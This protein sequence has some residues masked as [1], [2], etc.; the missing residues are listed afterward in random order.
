MADAEEEKMSPT[1]P[2]IHS[3]L[4]GKCVEGAKDSDGRKPQGFRHEEKKKQ[5]VF[6]KDAKSVDGSKVPRTKKAG[7][8]GAEEQKNMMYV[9]KKVTAEKTKEHHTAAES[10]DNIRG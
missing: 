8:D 1:S 4:A 10:K 2:P 3:S 9:P 5:V 6:A 7:N